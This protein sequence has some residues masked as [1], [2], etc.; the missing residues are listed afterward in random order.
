MA[1]AAYLAERF[2]YRIADFFRHWYVT[3]SRAHFANMIN[4]FERIDRFVALR[5]TARFLF[6]PLYGDYSVI[7]Y[8][9]GFIFR[10][11]RLI[12]G[13]LIYAVLLVIY[14]ALYL[15]WI[16]IPPYVIFRAVIFS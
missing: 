8:I 11:I 16:A 4:R 5:V 14:L 2:W 7:G 10:S 13:I 12:A 15:V 3:A 6:Q 9:L 1:T